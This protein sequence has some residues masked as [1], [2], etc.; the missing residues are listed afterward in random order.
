MGVSKEDVIA[1]VLA[2]LVVLCFVWAFFS[3][4]KS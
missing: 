1:Y 3:F 2:T 4:I